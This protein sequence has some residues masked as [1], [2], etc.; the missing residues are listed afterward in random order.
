MLISLCNLPVTVMQDIHCSV[1]DPDS[2]YDLAP[3]PPLAGF[4][5]QSS[6]DPPTPKRL[7]PQL[8]LPTSAS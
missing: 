2:A 7:P 8:P 3:N 6:G 1:P 5:Q 4:Q